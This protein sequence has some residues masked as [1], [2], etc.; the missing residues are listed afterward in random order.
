MD[1]PITKFKNCGLII[2]VPLFQR[3]MNEFL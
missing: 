2:D 1:I 3:I